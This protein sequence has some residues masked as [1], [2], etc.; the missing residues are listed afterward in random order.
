MIPEEEFAFLY[1][2][3]P[4]DLLTHDP[5]ESFEIGQ[6][7]TNGSELLRL[8]QDA[9][10]SLYDSL[11]RYHPPQEHG[12]WSKQSYAVMW[13]EP[14]GL[15]PRERVRVRI[16][17]IDGELTLDI[18][19]LKPM[20]AIEAAPAAIEDG[21]IGMWSGTQGE[22]HLAG[23]LRYIFSPESVTG[24]G[25]A[26]HKG[27]WE[28]SDSTLQLHPDVLAMGTFEFTLVTGESGLVLASPRGDYEYDAAARRNE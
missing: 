10:F 21:L 3:P 27:R 22:I 2:P 19:K 12:R 14:Y 25:L 11:N 24:V 26:G 20:F 6:W 15:L 16:T 4:G 5:T 9:S 13:L 28:L 1:P 7:W 8:N 23:D 17:R 18:P